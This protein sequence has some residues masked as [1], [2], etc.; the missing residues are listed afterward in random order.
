MLL[1]PTRA[2]RHGGVWVMR[3]L[4]SEPSSEPLPTPHSALG[5]SQEHHGCPHPE[6]PFAA[7][8]LV[9]S[10]WCLRHIRAS[11]LFGS[12]WNILAKAKTKHFALSLLPHHNTTILQFWLPLSQLGSNPEP[13][14]APPLRTPDLP[15]K[16]FEMF[17]VVAEDTTLPTSAPSLS[18]L[19]GSEKPAFF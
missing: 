2:S 5:V 13:P 1:T 19:L 6:K 17:T 14:F 16:P 10:S 4:C 12:K 3:E 18:S 8:S 7:N 9:F 11:P 15:P